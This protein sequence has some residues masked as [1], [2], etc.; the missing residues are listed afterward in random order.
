MDSGTDKKPIFSWVGGI[1]TQDRNMT[2]YYCFLKC[3]MIDMVEKETDLTIGVSGDIC[4][5]GHGFELTGKS[6]H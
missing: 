3:M 5:C 4:F 2:P 1:G 6:A